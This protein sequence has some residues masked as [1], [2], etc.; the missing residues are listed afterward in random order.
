MWVLVKRQKNC[1]LIDKPKAL[2]VE[3]FSKQNNLIQVWIPKYAI[4][5]K[6]I[7]GYLCIEEKIAI[8]KN[9]RYESI[10]KEPKKLDPQS[11]KI[12]TDLND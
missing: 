10:I 11:A 1:I 5:N 4:S 3:V 12:C 6:T 7:K 9:I 2:L 8:E